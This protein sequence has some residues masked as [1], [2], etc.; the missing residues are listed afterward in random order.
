[1]SVTLDIPDQLADLLRTLASERGVSIE[2]LG[3]QALAVGLTT[4]AGESAEIV[5]LGMAQATH[6]HRGMVS[7]PSPVVVRGPVRPLKITF[8]P[9]P[10]ASTDAH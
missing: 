1:M 8:E 2:E 6:P 10:E 3:E 5:D 4:L 7:M 9:D